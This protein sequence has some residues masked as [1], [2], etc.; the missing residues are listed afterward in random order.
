MRFEDVPSLYNLKPVS[1]LDIDAF[2]YRD[3]LIHHKSG[4]Q[5]P[6]D[7][8]INPLAISKLASCDSNGKLIESLKLYEYKDD[9]AEVLAG[10]HTIAEIEELL[11]RI[12]MVRKVHIHDL[13]ELTAQQAQDIINTNIVMF[14]KLNTYMAEKYLLDQIEQM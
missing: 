9:I 5:F 8:R 10:N 14:N 4:I 7:M 3:L 12:Y 1:K 13:A 6:N 2:K 11:D